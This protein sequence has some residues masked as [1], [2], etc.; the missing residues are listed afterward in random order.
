M[1]LRDRVPLPGA[2]SAAP[3]FVH[4]EQEEPDLVAERVSSMSLLLATLGMIILLFRIPVIL[5]LMWLADYVSRRGPY[6]LARHDHETTE[7][8]LEMLQMAAL[9]GMNVIPLALLSL[10]F[11]MAVRA[12]DRRFTPTVPGATIM[13]SGAGT[14]LGM[15][16]LIGASMLIVELV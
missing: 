11:L 12:W 15:L 16:G 6:A 5:G 7:Y 1:A 8:V 9:L 3:A 14:V 4:L 13:V 2:A 10:A